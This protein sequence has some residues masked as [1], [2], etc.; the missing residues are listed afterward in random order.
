MAHK[1][2]SGSSQICPHAPVALFQLP[3]CVGPGA[4]VYLTCLPSH[5]YW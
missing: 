2:A 4:S 3:A 1:Q 5:R